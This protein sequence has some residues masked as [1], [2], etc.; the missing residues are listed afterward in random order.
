M[1]T[2][3]E[4]KI[5]HRAG[6]ILHRECSSV[7]ACEDCPRN[8]YNACQNINAHDGFDEIGKTLQEI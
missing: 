6:E 5:L 7:K 8:I 4:R 3:T 2:E 1:L